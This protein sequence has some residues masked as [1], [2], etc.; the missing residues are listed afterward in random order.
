MRVWWTGWDSTRQL[1]ISWVR[2]I[3][4]LSAGGVAQI[5]TLFRTPLKRIASKKAS[6]EASGL[7]AIF[8]G[9]A[10]IAAGKIGSLRN[11]SY[12]KKYENAY[13]EDLKRYGGELTLEI[14][15]KRLIVRE[16]GVRE[17]LVRMR[18]HG[19]RKPLSKEMVLGSHRLLVL[20]ELIDGEMRI[21]SPVELGQ[22]A[23]VLYADPLPSIRLWVHYKDY[24]MGVV[25]DGVA[26][27][28]VYE[29]ATTTLTGREVD[30]FRDQKIRQAIL[31]AYAFKRPNIKVQLAQFQLPRQAFPVKVK[32]L[33]KPEIATVFRT[34]SE[35][36]AL[37][38]LRDF[39]QAFHV[40]TR[41]G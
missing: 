20:P 26:D 33:P 9:A 1:R 38:T 7:E 24:V 36:E 11:P 28:Y 29:F 32:D 19:R 6:R 17:L 10:D 37:A 15:N 31:Y 14:A 2:E 39:D 13:R 34:A 27:D 25:P 8:V 4:H 3:C 5:D 16:K 22:I 18:K 35:D 30:K 23:E 12:R 41:Q 21:D 40:G